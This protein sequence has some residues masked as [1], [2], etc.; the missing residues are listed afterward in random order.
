MSKSRARLLAELLNSAG[1]VKK[2]KSDLAGADSVIDLDTLPTITNA[3]LENSSISIAG[4]STALGGSVTLNTGDIGEHTNYKYY[5][6]ARARD[7]ISVGGNALSYNSSTGVITSNYEESPSFTGTVTAQTLSINTNTV[8]TTTDIALTDNAAIV[9]NSSISWGLTST[10]GYYRW[11]IGNTSRTGGTA[12][13]SEKMK[14]DASGNLTLS[15]TIDGRDIASDGSKLDGI[16]SN[17]NNYV[18]PTATSSAIGGVKIGYSENGKNYPV[19]LSSGQMYVNVPWVDTNTTYSVGDGGLTQKNFT[20]TL[21]DKLDGIESGATAD[22]TQS[23]I[24]A[25]GITATGLSGTPNITVG[26]V[27]GTYFL[28]SGADTTPAG[29]TFSNAFNGSTRVAYFDGDTATSVW[30][31][32]GNT[33]YAAIDANNGILR[34]HVN[35]T[36]GNWNERIQMNSSGITHYGTTTVISNNVHLDSTGSAY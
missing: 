25:L 8:G 24:N 3:K 12:G 9:G 19:E 34:L 26:S 1:R 14:L 21:K 29:T 17:A 28:A 15:G 4:H 22:Q 30:W 20:T 11:L 33:P 27:T 32:S 13:G 31:G 36:S 18:L 2:D 7:A 5:T 16:A 6:D 10:S 35:D 23:D